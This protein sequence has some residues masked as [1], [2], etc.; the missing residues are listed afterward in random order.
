MTALAHA[1]LDELVA[2]VV[3]PGAG[4][5]PAETLAL[6]GELIADTI[7]AIAA[8][9]RAPEHVA[10]VRARAELVDGVSRAAAGSA[11]AGTR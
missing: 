9:A 11:R 1:T 10:L 4:E 2:T 7:A 3:A 5:L 6:G 8:G